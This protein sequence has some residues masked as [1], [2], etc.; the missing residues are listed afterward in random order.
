MIENK[1][2]TLWVEKYRPIK[3]ENYIG[4]EQLI[5]KVKVYLLNQDIPH[6]LLSGTAGTGK[7]TL[8]KLIVNN[9][10]C[11]YIY[12]NASDENNV[13]TVRNKIKNFAST[14][15]FKELKIVILDEAD[16]ATINGQAALRAILEQ[17]SRNTR[18]ILTCN[19]IEKIIEPIRSRCQMFTITAPSMPE[20]A[21]H[22][23]KILDQECITYKKEDVV[24]IVKSTYPDIRKVI[25]TCQLNCINN[26]LELDTQSIVEQNYMM[27][28]VAI[29][30]KEKNKQN[31]FIG[32]RQLLADSK[33]RTFEHLYRF[34]YDSVSEITNDSTKQA[35]LTMHIADGQFK[36]VSVVDK[37]INVMAMFI[38]II[39]S[40]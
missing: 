33:V 40:L 2:H 3:L 34:M 37:E 11:D 26:N 36:D 6:L 23:F 31:A 13:D 28:I 5:S 4:N 10:E 17:F 30:K 38:N 15:G 19:Y 16:Y 9:I 25:N 20:V 27:K 39:N 8:A 18:F 24:T 21:K 7:T 29:L 35:E 1:E 22:T 32:V 14:I 12:I